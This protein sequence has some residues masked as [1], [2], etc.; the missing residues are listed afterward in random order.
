M[1]GG[2]GVIVGASPLAR[3]APPIAARARRKHGGWRTPTE[4]GVGALAYVLPARYDRN[5]GAATGVAVGDTV[6]ALEGVLLIDG[7]AV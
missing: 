3:D 1:Q 4:N 5:A 6:R 2:R 7:S